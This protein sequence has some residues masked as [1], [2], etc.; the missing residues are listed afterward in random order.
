MSEENKEKYL[1]TWDQIKD[2]RTVVKIDPEGL[3]VL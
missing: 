3:K 2:D 1:K